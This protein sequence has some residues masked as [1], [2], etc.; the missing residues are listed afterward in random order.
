MYVPIT[1]AGMS[2]RWTCLPTSLY[3]L[4]GF[5]TPAPGMYC[6]AVAEVLFAGSSGIT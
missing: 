4:T 1:F 2:I 5:V 6:V 3:W